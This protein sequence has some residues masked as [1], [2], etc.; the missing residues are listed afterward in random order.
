MQSFVQDKLMQNFDPTAFA[1]KFALRTAKS[2]AVNTLMPWGTGLFTAMSASAVSAMSFA[3]FGT[4]TQNLNRQ[5]VS[6]GFVDSLISQAMKRGMEIDSAAIMP[7]LQTSGHI[8][9]AMVAAWGVQRVRSEGVEC[10]R[11][12]ESY[13]HGAEDA[14][15]FSNFFSKNNNN[16]T[17][18]YRMG[19]DE[20]NVDWKFNRINAGSVCR[21]SFTILVGLAS[22]GT[23]ALTG[24]NPSGRISAQTDGVLSIIV[25]AQVFSRL[26]H[27]YGWAPVDLAAATFTRAYV[28]GVHATSAASDLGGFGQRRRPGLTR[29]LREGIKKIL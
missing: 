29:L 7:T 16:D 21:T 10:I 8:L 6:T 5:A 23:Q 24:S 14:A 28:L 20:R 9:G 27:L 3:F 19:Y 11:R 18:Y 17:D 26:I 25:Y 13:G 4:V 15:L 1:A 2:I 12:S 22:L